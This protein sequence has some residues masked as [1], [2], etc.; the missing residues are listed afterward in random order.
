MATDKRRLDESLSVEG[1]QKSLTGDTPRTVDSS[2]LAV[3]D[4]GI[5]TIVSEQTP[6][7]SS[8]GAPE[9]VP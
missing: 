8:E 7:P 4:N 3:D 6:S 2:V 1:F 9:K 5:V